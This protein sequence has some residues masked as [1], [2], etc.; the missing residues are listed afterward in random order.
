MTNSFKQ[1]LRYLLIC[2][3]LIFSNSFLG[4]YAYAKKQLELETIESKSI[5]KTLYIGEI[6]L[7]KFNNYI[8]EI[9]YLEGNSSNII[10]I[11]QQAAD[12][13]GFKMFKIKALNIG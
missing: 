6:E 1:I 7:L 11:E 8:S 2:S 10:N 12:A 13:N 3:L 4:T 9:F 5:N